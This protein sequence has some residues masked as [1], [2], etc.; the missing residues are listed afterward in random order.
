MEFKE[1]LEKSRTTA[2]YPNVGSNELYAV[3]GLFGEMGELLNKLKKLMRADLSEP[4]PELAEAIKNEL[5][6]VLWYIGALGYEKEYWMLTDGKIDVTDVPSIEGV[7]LPS[8]RKSTEAIVI[9][10]INLLGILHMAMGVGQKEIIKNV[11]I[12]VLAV[13][14]VTATYCNST[15][16]DVLDYNIAKL[17]ARQTKGQ[18]KNLGC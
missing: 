18:I 12:S 15:L 1:F 2:E 3:A 4:T 6:D 10:W 17:S 16:S 5:G 7:A 14:T 11:I 9:A 13:A 8:E